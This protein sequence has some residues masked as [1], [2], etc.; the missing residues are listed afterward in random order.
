MTD[1]Y[2]FDSLEHLYTS[3]FIY[4]KKFWI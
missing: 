4:N 3:Q 2:T 1:Q